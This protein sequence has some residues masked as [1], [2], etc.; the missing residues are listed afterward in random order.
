MVGGPT[1]YFVKFSKST[2]C[3]DHMLDPRWV[4]E[5]GVWEIGIFPVMFGKRVRA[6]IINSP[7]CVVDYCSGDDDDFLKELL[8][9]MII[10]LES[11]DESV[12]EVDIERILPTYNVKPI[13][14]DPCWAKLKKVALERH[15]AKTGSLTYAP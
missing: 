2:P 5:N 10:I 13:N 12:K 3:A 4:S 9:T 7:C 8:V 6:G 11:F 1:P 15:I 14:L